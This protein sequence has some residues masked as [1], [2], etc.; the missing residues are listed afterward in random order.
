MCS[1]NGNVNQKGFYKVMSN[2]YTHIEFYIEVSTMSRYYDD[3]EDDDSYEEMVAANYVEVSELGMKPVIS[4]MCDVLL[5]PEFIDNFVGPL[6]PR[7]KIS[8]GVLIKAMIINVLMGRTPIVH[9]EETFSQFECEILLGQGINPKDLNDDR[10]G[11]ALEKLGA[12]DYHKLYSVICMRA[13]ELH[14]VKVEEVHVDTTNISLQGSYAEP[15]LGE[16]DITFG[17]PKSGRKDLK[18]ANIGLFVQQD[19]LPIGGASLAGNTSDVV[20]FREAMEELSETFKGD[21]NT[22]PIGI[23]DAAGSNTVMFDKAV[24]LGMPSIIRLSD[25]FK[26]TR[27]QI[28]KAWEQ[29]GW[30]E[31]GTCVSN[32]ENKKNASNYKISS[33]DVQLGISEWRLIVVY[34]SALEKLKIANAKRNHP[35]YKIK[36]EKSS[37]KLSKIK[38][39]S[40]DEA[41]VAGELFIKENFTLKTPFKWEMKVEKT[42]IEKYLKKGKPTESSEKVTTIEYTAIVKVLDVDK[43]IYKQWLREES[44]FVLV[45]NVPI[46]RLSDEAILRDYKEQW[47]VEDKFKFLK[48][49]IILGPI[50]LQKK[51]R[52]NGLI[53]VLLLS[54][55]TSLYICYRIDSSLKN[56][57]NAKDSTSPI[58]E[59]NLVDKKSQVGKRILTSDGRL[60]EK[61]TYK[62]I[63]GVLSSLKVLGTF[64]GKQLVRKFGFGTPIRLLQMVELIGFNPS[65][66]LKPFSPKMD[67]W[68]YY[69]K[70]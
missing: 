66:Y 70:Q 3:Y 6:D 8:I 10:L 48:K 61:P 25:R 57:D 5:I 50:W 17:D 49:P 53:F 67:V 15:A 58:K 65:I 11:D 69:K 63:L 7:V 32:P 12:L 47:V 4:S 31:I 56:D 40:E 18:Q 55:L 9:V 28:N 21:I 24:S 37:I 27:E 43:D 45:T 52:I 35:K 29:D 13:I 42:I 23:Y 33:F 36:I 30:K 64:Q 46:D 14:D 62:V 39:A 38:F 51:E 54:V 22:R 68:K 34:S 26:I 19:G 60:V 59:N 1:L 2:I 20:W 41:K 44:C 16:F